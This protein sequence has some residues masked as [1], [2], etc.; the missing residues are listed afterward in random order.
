MVEQP[1][2]TTA[3]QV[4]LSLGKKV[5]YHEPHSDFNN[6]QSK[7]WFRIA[8][9]ED[10]LKITLNQMITLSY[11]M[12]MQQNLILYINADLKNH[13]KGNKDLF[14]TFCFTNE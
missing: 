14:I 12:L 6:E 11:K 10:G 13:Q 1:W 5:I 2:F 3:E 9:T 7:P 4:F 8:L